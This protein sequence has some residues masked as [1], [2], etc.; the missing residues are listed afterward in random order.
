MREGAGVGPIVEVRVV[1]QRFVFCVSAYSVSVVSMLVLCGWSFGSCLCICGSR[2]FGLQ[3]W[4]CVR[5]LYL[6]IVLEY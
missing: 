5:G 6:S 2:V 3:G 1:L 4:T